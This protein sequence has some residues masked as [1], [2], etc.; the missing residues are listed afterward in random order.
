M[1]DEITNRLIAAGF[2]E[3]KVF[4]SMKLQQFDPELS[5]DLVVLARKISTEESST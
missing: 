1:L 5:T 4:G 2:E 3:I